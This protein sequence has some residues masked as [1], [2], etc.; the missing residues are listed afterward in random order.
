MLEKTSFK[1]FVFKGMSELSAG[2]LTTGVRS[3]ERAAELDVN[4]APLNSFLGEHFFRADN[5]AMARNY[6]E[7]ALLAS[8]H[9][10]RLCLLLGLVYGDEG[11][12]ERATDLLRDVVRRG[13]ACFAAHY[14]LGRLLAA[15]ERWAEALVEFKDALGTRPSPEMHYVVGCVYYRLSRNRLAARHLRKAVEMNGAYSAALH[16]LGLVYMRSGNVARAECAFSAAREAGQDESRY[17]SN[18]KNRSQREEVPALPPLFRAAFHS[19]KRLVTSGDRRLAETMRD[20]ALKIKVLG[21]LV[22][23]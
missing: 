8:P 7:R 6:L 16:M 11:K 1:T 21:P 18:R 22:S 23:K 3:L 15:E 20:E 5:M 9:D 13:G 17:R 4:N 19:R 12:A 10:D 14:A 2:N